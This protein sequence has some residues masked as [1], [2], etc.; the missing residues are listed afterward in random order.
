[1]RRLHYPTYVRRL[2]MAMLYAMFLIVMAIGGEILHANSRT[3]RADAGDFPSVSTIRMNSWKFCYSRLLIPRIFTRALS[4]FQIA[5]WF[6]LKRHM[7]RGMTQPYLCDHGI[8]QVF[9]PWYFV[10]PNTLYTITM[11]QY[12]FYMARPVICSSIFS[13]A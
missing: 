9:S 2:S 6:C 3:S 12:C 1:M 10:Y 4:L 13:I 11:L 5:V 8:I 7:V